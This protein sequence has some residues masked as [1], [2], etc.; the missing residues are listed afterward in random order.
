MG[1]I[2]VLGGAGGVGRVAVEALTALPDSSSIVVADARPEAV[3]SVI[4]E[5]GDPRLAAA[6]V[7]VTNQ[8]ALASFL[9]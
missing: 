4:D 6:T 1:S 7:D 8:A 9:G 3:R 2:V 5:L